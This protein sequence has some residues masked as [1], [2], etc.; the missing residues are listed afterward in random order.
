M[1]ECHEFLNEARRCLNEMD[2]DGG[3]ADRVWEQ[4]RYWGPRPN[5]EIRDQAELLVEHLA[6]GAN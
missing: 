5:L 4:M 2:L 6:D 3:V 1:Y